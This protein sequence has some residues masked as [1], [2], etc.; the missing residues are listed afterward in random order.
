MM[1]RNQDALEKLYESLQLTCYQFSNYLSDFENEYYARTDLEKKIREAITEK[2]KTC[3]ADAFNST[4]FVYN[5]LNF[6]VDS[7]I[8]SFIEAEESEAP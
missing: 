4:E 2:L 1:D 5:I 6:D 8:L 3:L 7:E